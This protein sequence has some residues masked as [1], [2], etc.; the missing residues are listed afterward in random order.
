M[1]IAQRRE[2]FHRKPDGVEHGDLLVV[3]AAWFLAVEHLPQLRHRKVSRH[4]LQIALDPG[5]RFKLD[6]YLGG[7]QHIGVDLGLAGAIATH[8][9]QVHAGGQHI[10]GNDGR[11][12]LIGRDRG[13][14]VSA[15]H[16]I[17]AA[18]ADRQAQT[19]GVW[20]A[21]QVA[22]Q[23]GGG[24][25]VGVKQANFFNT[26]QVVKRQRLELALGAVADQC[27]HPAVRAGQCTGRNGRRSGGAHGG[28]QC[29]LAN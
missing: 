22:H 15:A 11:I 7:A 24:A 1:H 23:L 29:Q 18:V 10:G 16:C 21:L 28:C 13:D 27:H 19:G 20:V 3:V 14:D 17:G 12:G 4:L 5:L 26:H 6:K 25:G 9:I 8:R 2:V